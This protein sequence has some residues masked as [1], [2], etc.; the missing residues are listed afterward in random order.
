M[1]VIISDL[2][3]TD[4]TSGE[5]IKEGAFRIFRERLRDLAYAASWRTGKKYK[6]I[7]RLDLLLLGDILD[8]IRSAQWL[9]GDTRPWSDSQSTVFRQ[10]VAAIT[11][12]ILQNNA[13]SLACLKSLKSPGLCSL[14]SA[15]DDGQ[16][17]TVGKDSDSAGRSPIETHIHYLIGNHDWF[18]GLP[19]AKYDKV[20]ERIVDAIGLSNPPNE[21][22]PYDVD[23]SDKTR[24]VCAAHQVFAR[25][26]DLFDGFCYEGDRN[27]SSL[28]DALVVELL[29]RFP[30]EVIRQLG[31]QLPKE[32]LDGLKGIDN[33]WPLLVGPAWIDGLLRRTC[34]DPQ[35]AKG[36][37]EIWDRLADEFLKLEF[38]RDR[39]KWYQ[40]N[41]LVDRLERAL[42]FSKGAALQGLSRLLTRW[43]EFPPGRNDPF[44]KNALG[45]RSFKNRAARYLVYGHTHCH[46]V[47][48]LDACYTDQGLF[49]QMYLNA[50]TWRR[51]HKLAK[52]N[53][54]EEEF[55]SYDVMT[56]LAFFKDDERSGRRFESWSGVLGA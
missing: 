56:Y 19:G 7:E 10:K 21:P 11:D 50:G 47:I 4:G 3:L 51:V 40:W 24:A 39:D 33:V 17:K 30:S 31:R 35:Q 37:K 46:E 43:S 22:F 16:P 18:F 29:N 55:M 2:H 45:E 48:P 26:G 20:R 42:K 5:T 49:N 13:Q 44:Y 54:K 9:D 6:P 12:A 34:P 38:V 36:V 1:L 52:S 23:G 32:C 28:G 25:H 15:T 14:P 41:D 8:V 27:S 53:P